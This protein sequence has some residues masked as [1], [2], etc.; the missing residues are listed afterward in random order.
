MLRILWLIAIGAVLFGCS[1]KCKEQW[2]LMKENKL[3][4][5]YYETFK[6]SSLL[7]VVPIREIEKQVA[8]N[9]GTYCIGYYNDKGQ[10]ITVE[11]YLQNKLFFRF[12]YE[13][14]ETGALWKIQSKNENEEVHYKEYDKKGKLIEEY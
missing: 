12:E 11:K 2:P 3:G 1:I 6:K 8:L 5:M 14:Y 10:L 13:F 4:T 7:P 9:K